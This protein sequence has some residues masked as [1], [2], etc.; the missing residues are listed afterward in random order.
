MIWVKAFHLIFMVAWFAGLF[1]LPRI[2]V[3]LAMNDNADVQAQLKVMAQKLY[4]FITPWM[5]L[6]LFFGF[7]LL[8]GY[9]AQAFGNSWWLKIKLVLVT[10][11]VVY[12]FY[13]GRL[14]KSFLADQNLRSHVWYRWFNEVPVLILFAVI[15]LAVVKPW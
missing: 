9:G 15:I 11:L 7:W 1:Y 6:T 12:H 4:R 8:S 2:F 5:A 3:N 10:I 14:L 13:C